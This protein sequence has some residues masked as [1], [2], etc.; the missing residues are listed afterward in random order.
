MD[1]TQSKPAVLL[2][3]YTKNPSRVIAAAAR[4]STGKSAPETPEGCRE[5]V[6][7]LMV[8]EHW[9]PFEFVHLTFVLWTNRAVSHELVRH[10]HMSVVQRS[11]R[12]GVEDPVFFL[13]DELRAS[14]KWFEL[15]KVA[16]AWAKQAYMDLIESGVKPEDARLVLPNG[17]MTD[18]TVT[19][20]LREFRHFLS[21]RTNPAAWQP[22]RELA[23]AMGAAFI[24]ECPE[25]RCLVGDVLW[26][27]DPHGL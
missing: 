6:Q 5:F 14:P 25:D 4:V 10:R 27:D 26:K 23:Y 3:D 18:L 2:T 8:R 9:T 11:Q 1:N 7:K 15:F 22:M 12:Y 21:L 13:P 16:Y 19:M 24:R 20:N 17:T